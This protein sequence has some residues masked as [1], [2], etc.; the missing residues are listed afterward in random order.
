MSRWPHVV[1]LA[2]VVATSAVQ[3]DPLFDRGEALAALAADLVDAENAGDA[4]AAVDLF[5]PDDDI[6][7]YEGA[8]EHIGRDAA[9]AAL[10]ARLAGLPKGSLVAT[11]PRIL[12]EAATGW[13]VVEWEWGGDAGRHIT[14]AR[15]D[16][17]V[18]SLDALDFDGGSADAPIGA[19]DASTA[20]DAIDGPVRM[21]EKAA[22]AFAE[23]NQ[24]AIESL[25]VKQQDDFIFISDDGVRWEGTDGILIAVAAAA[26]GQVPEGI[27]REAMTLFVGAGLGRA[28]AFQ[29]IDGTR[30]SLQ[31]ERRD[32]WRIV[33]ASLSAPLDVLPVSPA[34]GV[35]TTWANL[36]RA[37]R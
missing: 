34:G 7:Y 16:G 4:A 33:K 13:I 24:G 21:M 22:A 20:A 35:I 19:F 1:A 32:G 9:L 36:R 15:R 27:S 11:A 26:F 18:W 37:T 29:E 30:V 25:I 6:A 28:I 10:T 31:L 5:A 17:G 3:A 2:L 8:N 12:V 23:G 14:R